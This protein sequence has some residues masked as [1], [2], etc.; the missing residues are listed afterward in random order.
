MCRVGYIRVSSKEQNWD[1]QIENLAGV[2]KV[3]S[4]K[5]SGGDGDRP[6]LSALLSFI[7]EGDIVVVSELDR[8]G[9]NNKELTEVMSIIHSKGAT[10]E[11]LNLPS[12]SG[13][14]DENLRQLLNNLIIEI[15]KYQ[16]EEERKR[17]LERQ[18]QGIEIAKRKGKYKGRKPMFKRNDI[19]LQHAFDLFLAGH[20]DREVEELVGINARTFRRYREKYNVSRKKTPR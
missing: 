16:A 12:L 9:R 18:R 19:K 13:I 11:I 10:I 6:G 20:S 7:R 2:S 1:R 15:Y 17:I 5:L 4:D 3:F 8:L 14:R